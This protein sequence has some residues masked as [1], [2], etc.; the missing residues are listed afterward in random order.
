MLR[1]V[2][3]GVLTGVITNIVV[4]LIAA[5]GHLYSNEPI[6]QRVHSFGML[7]LVSRF[8][9]MGL[10]VILWVAVFAYFFL[11]PNPDENSTTANVF[12]LA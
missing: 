8:A 1:K 3:V 11:R 7:A 4:A 2:A 6:G 12:T 5:L 10:W 9:F